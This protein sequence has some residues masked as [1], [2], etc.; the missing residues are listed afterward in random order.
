[1]T[2]KRSLGQRSRSALCERDGSW[3]TEC[4]WTQTYTDISYSWATNSL[5]Y[6]GHE[7]K[8]QGHWKH[9]PEVQLYGGGVRFA[10]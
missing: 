7:F 4:I 5:G 1:M 2:L 9:F 6:K 3:I 8:G 10:V